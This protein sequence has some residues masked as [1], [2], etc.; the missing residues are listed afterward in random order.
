MLY[1]H[2]QPVHGMFSRCVLEIDGA[3]AHNN[4]ECVY[5][6]ISVICAFCDWR[7]LLSMV[8][9]LPRDYN[10][11]TV[12]RIRVMCSWLVRRCLWNIHIIHTTYI[13]AENHPPT[14]SPTPTNLCTYIERTDRC[15][16][17]FVSERSFIYSFVQ[18][19]WQ[20]RA[21]L[22]TH[23]THKLVYIFIP[24]AAWA[25]YVIIFSIAFVCCVCAVWRMGQMCQPMTTHFADIWLQYCR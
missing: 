21:Y 23:T 12:V 22:H 25:L 24:W 1:H 6:S 19:H 15:I 11:H 9:H 18:M 14:P 7:L 8:A 3:H 10:I 17:R 2:S 13:R 5:I 16:F 4:I 20:H